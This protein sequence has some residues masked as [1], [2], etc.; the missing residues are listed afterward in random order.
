MVVEVEPLGVGRFVAG[1]GTRQ[2]GGQCCHG[3]TTKEFTSCWL[4][5]VYTNLLCSYGRNETFPVT[6]HRSFDK[7]V[8]S[9]TWPAVP[10]PKATSCYF[11]FGVV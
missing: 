8:R 3:Q 7:S 5:A 1:T 6:C 11:A 2:A 10:D 9:T 4:N